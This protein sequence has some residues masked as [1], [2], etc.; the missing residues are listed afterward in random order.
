LRSKLTVAIPTYN[1]AS[2]LRRTLESVGGLQFRTEIDPECV[3]VDNGSTDDTPAAIRDF[4]ACAA[5]PVRG[6]VEPRTGSSFARNRAIDEARGD[7]IFFLDDDVIVESDWALELLAELERR[8]LDAAC[9]A[10]LP[11]WL[12]PPP[13]WLG[14]RLYAKLAVHHPA[15][16]SGSSAGAPSE[17]DKL[18]YYFSANVGFRRET[19]ARFGRFR[20]DLGVFAGNPTSGEE[21]E[22]FAR[23]L[24]RGGVVGF[25]PRARVHHLIG[26][27]RTTRS[28]MLRKSFAYGVGSACAGGRTHNRLDKLMKNVWRMAVAAAKR[29]AEG[30]AYHQLECANF[31][32]YW[33]GRLAGRGA[34]RD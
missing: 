19:F 13:R 23:I 4:G 27:E 28:Y 25:A 17:L 8:R 26:P 9:G 15:M 3:V 21:T 20:E 29:D 34:R 32:G 1:R 31:F 22:L 14:P 24:A 11:R 30:V 7:F 18:E 33:R 10:V 6:V 2:T 5:F 16:L 12:V